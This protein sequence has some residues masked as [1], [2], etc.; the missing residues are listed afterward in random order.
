MNHLNAFNAQISLKSKYEGNAHLIWAMGLYLNNANFSELASECLTDGPDDR[1]IDFIKLDLDNERL[2]LAQGYFAEKSKADKA[3]AN[4]AADLNTAAAWLLVGDLDKLPSKSK[5]NASLREIIKESRKAIKN[6]EVKQIELLYVHNL[7]QSV[8]VTSELKTVAS[9]LRDSLPKMTDIIVISKELG[10]QN[11]EELYNIQK[12]AILIEST[13]ECPALI[14]FEQIGTTWSAAVLSVPGSWLR[15]MF[16]KHDEK[17]FSANYR[18]FLG[19]SKRRPINNIIKNTAEK[20]SDNFWVFNNGITILTFDYKKNNKTTTIKGMS[21]INGAQT[22]GSIGSV[23]STIDL[24]GVKVLC[25]LIK[26]QDPSTVDDIILYNN[27]QN[28]IMT[29][30]KF[31]K[32]PKQKSLVEEFKKFGH[33]YSLKRGFDP[34]SEL[35][36]EQV[37][38]SLLALRGYYAEANGGK[39]KAFMSDAVF[40]LAFKDAQARHI[41]FAFCISRAID[42]LRSALKEKKDHNIIIEQEEKQLIL[43]RNLKFKYFLI[44]VFGKCIDTLL[45]KKKDVKIISFSPDAAQKS[46][47]SIDDLVAEALPA[48]KFVLAFTVAT[49]NGKDFTEFLEEAEPLVK[50][51][52]NVNASLYA[53]L[54]TMYHPGI[55]NFKKIIN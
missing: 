2:I 1:K 43:L 20:Q 26:C 31:S 51:S 9:Y 21:I 44:S 24:S 55:E 25:R 23:D 45:G 15:D 7:P 36:I 29:W 52:S 34:N 19:I 18:G 8:H 42:E 33:S 54:N 30:D 49:V 39:N 27:T 48:V 41:L 40:D 50:I 13:E 28:K 4:K 17:L 10:L 3:P 22:T 53:V 32:D 38:Q 37:I 5:P 35:G 6:G 47:K 12:S 14:E 16:I 11:I 46:N